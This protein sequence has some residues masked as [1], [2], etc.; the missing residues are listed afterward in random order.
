MESDPGIF[1]AVLPVV[2]LVLLLESGAR[3]GPGAAEPE[4]VELSGPGSQLGRQ[5][6]SES[7]PWDGQRSCSGGVQAG[8]R[9]EGSSSQDP[10]Q[11]SPGPPGMQQFP[12]LFFS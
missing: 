8:R 11:F 5:S 7:E 12:A 1:S 9:K 3:S 6:V 4:P 10:S 2:G